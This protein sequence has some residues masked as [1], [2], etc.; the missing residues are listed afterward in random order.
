[1]RSGDGIHTLSPGAAVEFHREQEGPTTFRELGAMQCNL[2]AVT[3]KQWKGPPA[4]TTPLGVEA[5]PCVEQREMEREREA[6][7]N[8]E[9]KTEWG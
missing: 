2:T 5:L 7:A 4:S 6:E 8:G 9:K 1:M 3:M